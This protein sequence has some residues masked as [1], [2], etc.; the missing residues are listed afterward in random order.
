MRVTIAPYTPEWEPAV[1]AFNGRLADAGIRYRFPTAGA[2][3]TAEPS[4]IVHR[5][6]V[7]VQDRDV[8][9]GYLLQDQEFWLK[10][11]SVRVAYLHL[12]LSEGLIDRR[13]GALGVQLIADALRRHPLLFGLG[14]GGRDETFARVVTAL[15]WSIHAVPFLFRI[16]RPVRVARGLTAVRRSFAQRLALDVAALTGV[17]SVGCRILQTRRPARSPSSVCLAPVDGFDGVADRLWERHRSHYRLVG[18]RDQAALRELY[19]GPSGRYLRWE[20]RAEHGAVGWGVALDTQMAGHR[21]FGDLRLGTIVDLFGDPAWAD[22]LVRTITDELT[23]R[24]ADLIVTNQSSAVW[25][26]ACRRSGFVP[27]PTN[28]LFAASPGLTDALGPGGLDLDT[29]HLTRGDGDGP[30]HL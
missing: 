23:R 12:P 2:L 24:G 20:L 9:G 25:T 7:A 18:C 5:G 3:A 16:A 11:R 13:Y 27:G 10:G 15:R 14:I 26:H 28:F 22:V 29:L 21:H 4:A 6:F 30:I 1:D 8:H 19:A 17:A